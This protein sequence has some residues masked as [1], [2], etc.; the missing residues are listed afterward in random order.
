MT[1]TEKGMIIVFFYCLGSIIQVAWLIRRPWST[2]K[3]FLACATERQSLDNLPQSGRPRILSHQQCGA[4]IQAA[5]SSWKMNR[6]DFRDKYAPG[7]SLDTGMQ[8]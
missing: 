5:K 1:N 6:I 4:I 8:E 7:V 2:V 3:S